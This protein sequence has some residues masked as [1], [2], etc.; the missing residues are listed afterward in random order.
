MIRHVVVSVVV[1][2][3]T[4]GAARAG[5]ERQ[6]SALADVLR[7]LDAYLLRYE[8]TL[9]TVVAEEHYRQAVEDTSLP[10]GGQLTRTL[11]SDYALA[12]SPGGHAWTGFR[13]TYEV[14]GHPVR[15]RANRLQALMAEGSAES[16]RQALR[17]S[18]E[19]A[20]YNLGDDIVARTINVPTVALEFIHPRHR[21]RVS[22]EKRGEEVIDDVRAWVLSFRERARPTLLRTPDGK[23]RRARGAVWVDPV[24]GDVL[25]TDLSWE[26]APDG[27]IVVH[28]G[29]DAG[30]GALVPETMLEEYRGAG[31]LITGKAT[32][33]NYRRFSTAARV[34]PAGET[35][36]PA[37]ASDPPAAHGPR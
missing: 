19:N 27:Y 10:S 31:G 32:Y 33:T 2:L 23:D 22:F 16:A 36:L 15:D 25:R 13:D 9:A 18:R 14:D 6:A 3:V 30:V 1:G 7:H 5:A 21:S 11:I 17:I 12:R 20:R 28:Y 4:C 37:A 29:R 34:L 26:G 8:S 35:N 24:G